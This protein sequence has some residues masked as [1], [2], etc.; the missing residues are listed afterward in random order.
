MVLKSYHP[1]TYLRGVEKMR[2][3][4]K[5]LRTLLDQAIDDEGNPRLCGREHCKEL[6]RL[7]N[8]L[9]YDPKMFESFGNEKTGMMNVELL[10]ALREKLFE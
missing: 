8:E 6:I 7:A 9:F 4:I 1:R 10:V 3:K 2:G 5:H